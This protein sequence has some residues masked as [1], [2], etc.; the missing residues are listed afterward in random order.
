MEFQI[1]KRIPIVPIAIGIGTTTQK[2][3][4]NEVVEFHYLKYFFAQFLLSAFFIFHAI[5]SFPQTACETVYTSHTTDVDPEMPLNDAAF[6]KFVQ[7]NINPVLTREFERS[8][9]SISHL[10]VIFTINESG[11]IVS[12]EFPEGLSETA[13]NE[14]A[15]EFI[16]M[17]KWEPAT[18][19]N[20]PVCAQAITR[21]SCIKL[22]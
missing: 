8:G 13:R 9:N 5:P 16:K 4:N 10:R 17:G 1:M 11:D 12:I 21:I 15:Q 22:Q 7:K 2:K 19:K 14:L 6:T 3:T 20:K 18:I